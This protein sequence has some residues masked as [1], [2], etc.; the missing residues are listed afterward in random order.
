M[1]LIPQRCIIIK[2]NVKERVLTIVR[3]DNRDKSGQACGVD[4]AIWRFYLDGETSASV[5]LQ[6]S[7]AAFVGNA[8]P[9]APCENT[10]P[11]HNLISVFSG[12]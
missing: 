3:P 4:Y 6:M 8:D 12:R 2:C 1:R 10:P 9:S 5:E 11:C 7:Q